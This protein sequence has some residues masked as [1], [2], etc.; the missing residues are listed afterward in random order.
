MKAILVSLIFLCSCTSYLFNEETAF[1]EFP[2]DSDVAGWRKK[3]AVSEFTISDIKAH[4]VE[5]A[6]I[7]SSAIISCTV[8]YSS[9]TGRLINLFSFLES[10]CFVNNNQ[11]IIVSSAKHVNILYSGRMIEIIS[12]D[13]SSALEIFEKYYISDKRKSELPGFINLFDFNQKVKYNEESFFLGAK[14]PVYEGSLTF[15]NDK[16][17]FVTEELTSEVKNSV[18]SFLLKRRDVLTESLNE[19]RIFFVKKDKHYDVVSVKDKHIFGFYNIEKIDE[20]KFLIEKTGKFI[21][22]KGK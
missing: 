17:F 2:S 14:L 21:D 22:E 19:S 5:Y 6:S 1:E 7:N 20:G 11:M 16:L 15:E 8:Y 18:S 13:D 10:S 9:N 4:K 3:S 12:E